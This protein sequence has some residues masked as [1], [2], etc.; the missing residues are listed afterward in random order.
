MSPHQMRQRAVAVMVD[1][2]VKA[3][4]KY[5]SMTEAFWRDGKKFDLRPSIDKALDKLPAEVQMTMPE[6]EAAIIL[7]LVARRAGAGA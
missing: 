1:S 3:G 7:Q 5:D 6:A 4:L 2:V